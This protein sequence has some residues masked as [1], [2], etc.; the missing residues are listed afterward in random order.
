M[1]NSVSSCRPCGLDFQVT[2]TYGREPRSLDQTLSAQVK[3]LIFV[4]QDW[5]GPIGMGALAES[6]ELLKGAVMLN[7]GLNAP[8][9]ARDLSRAH[10]LAKSPITGEI[11]LEVVVSVFPDD[12]GR[13]ELSSTRC[14]AI[15]TTA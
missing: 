1:S 3:E 7:T 13:S 11:L 8:R 5:G 4:G 12:P 6:P 2:P 9:E 14:R 10:A 15:R